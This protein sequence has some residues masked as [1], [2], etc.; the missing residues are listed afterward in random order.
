MASA[1]NLLRLKIVEY[2][3]HHNGRHRM[4]NK[5]TT[6]QWRDDVQRQLGRVEES[7]KRDAEDRSEFKEIIREVRDV[8]GELRSAVAG[9]TQT[10]QS[11]TSQVVALNGEKCG[12]RLDAIEERDRQY[13]QKFA[14]YDRILGKA[15]TFAWRALGYLAI[16]ALTGASAAKLIELL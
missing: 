15:N 10:V 11:M 5:Q 13:D 7:Q 14:R 8:T 2:L 1:K 3:Q 12:Q 9:L 16:A 6:D 4:V